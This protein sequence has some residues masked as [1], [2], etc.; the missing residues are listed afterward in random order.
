[1][2]AFEMVNIRFINGGINDWIPHGKRLKTVR[3]EV[4][5][6]ALKTVG[7]KPA[8]PAQPKLLPYNIW[9]H[10]FTH[11]GPWNLQQVEKLVDGMAIDL[12]TLPKEGYACEAYIS[13]SQTRNLSATRQCDD[14][15]NLAT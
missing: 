2:Q 14:E 11:L 5:E 6:H 3:D 10:R 4:E 9:H 15:W 1:M 12:E 13:G 7:R 8:E